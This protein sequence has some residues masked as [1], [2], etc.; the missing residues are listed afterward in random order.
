MNESSS[1]VGSEKF[2]NGAYILKNDKGRSNS[3]GDMKVKGKSII[4]MSSKKLC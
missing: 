1:G 4:N 3:F 2:P